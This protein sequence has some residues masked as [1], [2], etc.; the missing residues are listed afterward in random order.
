[1]S[2]SLLILIG[3]HVLLVVSYALITL[4]TRGFQR[5]M[6]SV[7]TP[8]PTRADVRSLIALSVL[9]TATWAVL[10]LRGSWR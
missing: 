3:G 2:D 8:H 9:W 10:W 6:S 7:D 4:A 5:N 1:M